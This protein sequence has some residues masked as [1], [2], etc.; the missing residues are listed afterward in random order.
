M[1]KF[2]ND[3]T[4]A[5]C[6][7]AALA[8][9]LLPLLVL[10]FYNHP[11]ADD[12]NYGL[13]A[14]QA[15]KSGE[16][17]L[18]VIAAAARKTAETYQ[19]WQGTFSAIFLMALHPAVFSESC[20]A[21]TPFL[22]LGSVIFGTF[23]FLH[24][25]CVQQ[26]KMPR[27]HWVILSCTLC[28]F[29]IQF[30]PNAFEGFYWYNASL[31][32]TFYYGICLCCYSLLLK[33]FTAERTA[34]AIAEGVCAALLAIFI[35]GGNYPTALLT[36]V[37]LVAA[38]VYAVW[39]KLPR[40][41]VIGTAICLVLEAG[42]FLIS[43]RA[44]GNAVRQGKF[45]T[46][47]GAVEAIFHSLQSAVQKTVEYTTLPAVL[48]ILLLLPIFLHTAKKMKFTFR[49]PVLAPVAMICILGIE[50]TPPYYAMTS[51]GAQRIHD[52]YYYTYWLLL[53][54]VVFYLC[55]WFTHRKNVKLNN[56][57]S[58]GYMVG[59]AAILCLTLVCSADFKQIHCV[60]AAGDLL[61]G[62]AAEY[63]R[64]MSERTA[65]LN[66]PDIKDVVL[67]PITAVPELFPPIGYVL[68]DDADYL[69]N[70]RVAAFYDKDT[71]VC[72]ETE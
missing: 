46:H 35:G 5:I 62:T 24:T 33:F 16:S 67:S 22:M 27:A 61:N 8:I 15:V 31:F 70:Q 9:S 63:H 39:K 43:V 49:F 71:V 59:V 11:C 37:L 41:R 6:A 20:Y 57:F 12:Y 40:S 68:S 65:L 13:Y 28:F 2:W 19:N 50:M 47:P 32:Y 69:T 64:Q 53:A 52:L 7:V 3:K 45:D 54:A 44:P 17:V 21:I 72:E 1:K 58:Q 36:C 51:L 60:N 55:G 42:A 23:F 26:L 10:G 48:G 18:G 66:D 4:L 29:S 34:F 38:V 25:L 30:A 56:E 14:A